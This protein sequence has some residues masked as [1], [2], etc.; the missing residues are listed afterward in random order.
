[1]SVRKERKDR[2]NETW[3]ACQYKLTLAQPL[4][5]SWS[6]VNLF[7]LRKSAFICGSVFSL[8]LEFSGEVVGG[9]VHSVGQVEAVGF[10]TLHTRVE[11]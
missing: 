11:D 10:E 4:Y 3:I 9:D 1:M 6:S 8:R 7:Y 2:K 5:A